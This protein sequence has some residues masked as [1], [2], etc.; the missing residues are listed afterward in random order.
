MNAPP[1]HTRKI[2]GLTVMSTELPV[3][4]ASDL[5]PEILPALSPL[6]SLYASGTAGSIGAEHLQSLMDDVGKAL[7]GGK[8][9]KLVPRVLFETV[10][11]APV[12]DKGGLERVE[13]NTV[14]GINLAFLGPRKK[15]FF[16]VIAF[17]VEVNF[18]SFFD[19][20]ALGALLGAMAKRSTSETSSRS[21]EP[22][23]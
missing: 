14:D 11:V 22:A 2:G 19:A 7:S 21:T 3:V 10:V 13:L 12:G 16:Q 8:F 23:E 17:A 4:D 1:T 5:I 20:G 18:L 15:I 9:R 6:A